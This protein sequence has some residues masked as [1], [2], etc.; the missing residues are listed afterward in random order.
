AGS[1]SLRKE[2][3]CSGRFS[4]ATAGFA[5]S[6]AVAGPPTMSTISGSAPRAAPTILRTSPACARSIISKASTGDE[7]A[8]RGPHPTTCGGTYLGG[9]DPVERELGEDRSWGRLGWYRSSGPPLQDA[10][11]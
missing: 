8:S 2:G 9:R 1:R 5:R 10:D 4:T 11:L 3:R 7:S 6:H